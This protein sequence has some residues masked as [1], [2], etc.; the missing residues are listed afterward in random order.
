MM[1]HDVIMTHIRASRSSLSRRRLAN[2]SSTSTL[3][4]FFS[5]SNLPQ[6][7][8]ITM[9]SSSDVRKTCAYSAACR[10]SRS[11][12]ALRRASRRASKSSMFF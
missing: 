3:S 10:A 9:T 4:C 12:L 6:Q 5:A 1:A 7:H 11:A 8:H 2:R